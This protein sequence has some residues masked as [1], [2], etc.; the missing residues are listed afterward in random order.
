[1]S[2][3]TQAVVNMV[4]SM[5]LSIPSKPVSKCIKINKSENRPI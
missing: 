4:A 1:M 5:A 2:V 3:P